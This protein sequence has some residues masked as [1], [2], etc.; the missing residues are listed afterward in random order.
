MTVDSKKRID[1]IGAKSGF[2]GVLNQ[3]ADSKVRIEK[4]DTIFIN[5]FL[6]NNEAIKAKTMFIKK[7]MKMNIILSKIFL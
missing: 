1:R 5:L 6:K 7:Y 3:K 4:K 2:P